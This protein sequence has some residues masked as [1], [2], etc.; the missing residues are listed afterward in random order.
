MRHLI[1]PLALVAVVLVASPALAQ[2]KKSE[3]AV[4]VSV[5]S[6]AA[7]GDK[8]VVTLTL[9]VAKGWHTYANPV[10]N[11]DLESATT[12]VSFKAG[13]KAVKADI[14]YPEGK[15]HKDSVVGDYK[16]YE[17]SFTVTATLD[18]AGATE[19]IEG[20]IAIQVCDEKKCLQPGKIKVKVE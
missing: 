14:K 2:P 5:K 18:L 16:I 11:K 12:I 6:E 1:A 4:K 7:K 3:D 13:G 8:K 9:D 17:G 19:P 10:G 20:E 15:V